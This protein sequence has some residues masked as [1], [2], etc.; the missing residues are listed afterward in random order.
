MAEK[1]DHVIQIDDKLYSITAERVAN[2]LTINTT[3]GG[4]ITKVGEFDG[5]KETEITIEAGGGDAD[6]A[7]N[8][9]KIQVTMDNNVKKY[10]TITVKSSEPIGGSAG[11]LWFKY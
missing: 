2:K 9:D 10:A 8:A 1:L 4:V 6:S 11:D 5:S 3:K 7:E